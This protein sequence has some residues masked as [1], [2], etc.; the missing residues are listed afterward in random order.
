VQTISQPSL[1]SP[2]LPAPEPREGTSTTKHDGTNLQLR[3]LARLLGRMAARELLSD[4][5]VR[6]SDQPAETK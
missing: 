5:T 1:E 3:A 4:E 2:E 6:T